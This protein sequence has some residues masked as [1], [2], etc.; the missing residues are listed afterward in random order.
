MSHQP[1]DDSQTSVLRITRQRPA[2][3]D[4]S[5]IEYLIESG[6]E[7]PVRIA[8][9]DSGRPREGV[10]GADSATESIQIPP[11]ET[12]SVT[13]ED[14]RRAEPM[15]TAVDTNSNL[16]DGGDNVDS[17]ATG[18]RDESS[19]DSPETG[20]VAAAV[21]AY[22]E[23]KTIAD[24]VTQARQYVDTVFVV[25][26]GS[27]DNTAGRAA[28]AGATVIEHSYNQGYGAALKTIFTEADERGIDRLV[29]LDGDGQHD[30]EDIPKL[31]EAQQ[32]SSADIVI[33]N[34]FQDDA[35]TDLPR[36]RHLGVLLI[37]L[38]TN[39]SMGVVRP[40]SYIGDTQSG[41]RAY[42]RQPIETLARDTTVGDRMGASTDILHH[43]HRRD[44]EVEE[45]GTTITYDVD[46]ANHY[47]P[48]RHGLQLVR[49]I[50]RTIKRERPILIL[51]VPGVLV[52]SGGIE[53]GFLAF[54][55]Y[56]QTGVFPVKRT[57]LA[58]IAALIGI[59]ACVT[60]IVLHSLNTIS[61]LHVG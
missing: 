47:S 58:T 8:F 27:E 25:D 44:Y 13:L 9:D 59:L 33:G 53:L 34:R 50:V 29:V 2:T 31:L 61:D 6:R 24:V 14:G 52:A 12:V 23:A 55:Y 41:F 10:A 26:D 54:D 11:G 21:P 4:R 51:G 39:L 3:A 35:D 17:T 19:V 56:S 15:I 5:R 45:V 38:L 46:D 7:V 32:T 16:A 60:A 30:P 18:D 42:G 40:R 1:Q 49:N 57:F 37:T 28:E 43:A 22:N 20:T 48:V 36:Y